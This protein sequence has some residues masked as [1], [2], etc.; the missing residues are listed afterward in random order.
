M[1]RTIIY[2]LVLT[3]VYS[4]NRINDKD[5]KS[6][7]EGFL[8]LK[9]GKKYEKMYK[10]ISDESKKYAPE[11]DFIKYYTDDDT[12]KDKISK[13][14]K[15]AEVETD[16]NKPQYKRFKVERYDVVNKDTSRYRDY[17]TFI[18]QKG[19]WKLLWYGIIKNKANNYSDVLNY[20]KAI[21]L[22]NKIVEINPYEGRAYFSLGR[23]YY[24]M[25][26][27]DLLNKNLNKAIELEP[28][29][30]NNYNLK[31]CYYNLLG[32]HQDFEIENF[33]KAI[34]F[35]LNKKDNCSYYSN[36][37]SNFV[38]LEK[39]D[40]ALFHIDKSLKIDSL[41][42]FSWKIKGRIFDRLKKYEEAN[43]YFKKAI[44]LKED[45]IIFKEDNFYE[46]ARN[47]YNLKRFDEAKRYIV[48]AL[49]IDNNNQKWQELYE[50]IK[51]EMKE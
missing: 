12:I 4:C 41:E 10:L 35:S 25:N 15:I 33:K 13:I 24:S 49:D 3:V 7:L 6:V 50:K 48:K 18:N 19:K 34:S 37:S 47:C 44:N 16:I 14:T 2:L 8:K 22:F 17:Y 26:N 29:Y 39:Y 9:Q 32:N 36:I 51:K 23:C 5:A 45:K 43:I 40:S 11:P 28:D 38:S 31:G 30:S 21:D 46:Y 27:I 42:S 1:K 20:N